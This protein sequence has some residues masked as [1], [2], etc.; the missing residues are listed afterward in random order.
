MIPLSSPDTARFAMELL[1][2]AFLGGVIGFE[3]EMHGQAAGL[4]TNIL[5][6]VGACLMMQL[7]LNM[8]TIYKHL[9]VNS[10]IRIDPGRI[11]SYAISGMGFLGAGAIIK[12]ASMIRGLTTATGLWLVTGVGLSV[13]AGFYL[14]ASLTI[15]VAMLALYGLRSL[16]P[17]FLK[18]MFAKI[19]L[20]VDEKVFNLEDVEKM[21]GEGKHTAIEFINYRKDLINQ[22]ASY[23]LRVV[24]KGDEEWREIT[25][26]LTKV[27]GV[28]QLSWEERSVP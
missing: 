26:A 9:D 17:L 6:C 13:G 3:R 20:A 25:E 18:D 5:I 22:T 2:A 15:L 12:G 24:S 4:R 23:I 11:A 21:V 10:P 8:E 14:P 28:T 7:S 16:K 1:L 27:P 19:T